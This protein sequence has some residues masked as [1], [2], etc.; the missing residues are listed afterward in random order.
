M[1]EKN[2]INYFKIHTFKIYIYIYDNIR[3]FIIFV[4]NILVVSL[5]SLYKFMSII[6]LSIIIINVKLILKWVFLKKIFPVYINN[7]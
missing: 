1:I 7:V 3:Y 4:K 6:I 2:Y 5:F